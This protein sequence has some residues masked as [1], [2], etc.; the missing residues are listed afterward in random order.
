MDAS[1]SVVVVGQDSLVVDVEGF[2]FVARHEVDVELGYADLAEAV[3]LLAMLLDGA[4]HAEAVDYFVGDEIGVVAA[5]FAVV[6]IIVR[7]AVLDERGQRGRKFFR[8][9][10]RDEVHHVIG[11]EGG[12]P[13]DMFAGGFQVVGGP[14][15]GG[16]H[17]FDLAEVAAGFFGAFADE[18]EAPVNQVGVGELENDAIADASGGSQGFGAV[19]SDPDAGDFAIGPGKFRGDAVEVDRFA[20]VQVAEDAYKF[21]EVLG[22]VGFFARTPGG[23]VAGPF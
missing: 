13:A 15:G 2:F 10:L 4:Y 8:F 1:I 20:G 7:A 16:G 9:V 23:L 21:L 3:E 6:E 17:D 22:V 5:D 19:A 12:K 11:N 18:A 14:D